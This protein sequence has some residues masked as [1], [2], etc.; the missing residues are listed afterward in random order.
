GRAVEG[1]DVGWQGAAGWIGGARV[2]EPLVN[3]WALL[4]VRRRQIDRRHDRA[5]RRLG[6]LSR[7]D[8]QRAESRP[9]RLLV[10][11]HAALRLA[12]NSMT[13]ILVMMS[14]SSEPCCTT[15]ASAP[16]RRASTRAREATGL[17][18]A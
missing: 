1:R 11:A 16:C 2:I 13:S 7:V 5:C 8:R 18:V 6:R 12:R 15:T 17:T 14:T 3:P 4:C 10:G 9:W